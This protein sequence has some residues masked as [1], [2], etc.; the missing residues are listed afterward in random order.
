ML[1]AT[2]CPSSGEIT[3]SMRQLFFSLYG[4][5]SGLHTGQPPIRSVA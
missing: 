5:L 3:V 4:W 1:R 2:M